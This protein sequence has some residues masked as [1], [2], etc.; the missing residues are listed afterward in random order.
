MGRTRDG[1]ETAEEVAE[2]CMD[3]CSVTWVAALNSAGVPA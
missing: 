3:Y 2:V 1:A